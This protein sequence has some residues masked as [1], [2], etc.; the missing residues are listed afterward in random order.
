MKK[1]LLAGL[2]TGLLLLILAPAAAAYDDMPA[3]HWAYADVTEATEAGIF[4]GLDENTFGRGQ[5]ITRAQFATALVRLMG[6]ESVS[7]AQPSYRDCAPGRWYYAAVETARANGALPAYGEEFR[8][9]DPITR[10]DMTAMLVR[11]LGYSSLAGQLSAEPAPFSDVTSNRGYITVAY[12]MGLVTG[13]GGL[14]RPRDTAAREEAAA[15]LMRVY[16]KL[17]A[18]SRAL[19]GDGDGY[20]LIRVPSPEA[21]PDTAIPTTPLEPSLE[22]YTALRTCRR[23]GLDPDRAAVV[24]R[25]GGIATQ[26]RGSQILS[27][28]PVSAAQVETYLR[29]SRA[30]THYSDQ[31]DSAY[32]V[33]SGSPSTTV[34]YQ[35]EESLAAKLQLCRMFGVTRYL[36]EDS[37]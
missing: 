34:W 36:L 1:N 16:R 23:A 7:P 5:A 3:A 11:A 33:I 30:E 13:A 10:E 26:V 4:Q 22:L 9:N 12:D 28:R 27:S 15:I 14:F 18:P 24:L 21:A 17:S 31:Y 19:S 37:V 20:H 32:L 2:L 25:A 6:W 35:S 8:P 29:N